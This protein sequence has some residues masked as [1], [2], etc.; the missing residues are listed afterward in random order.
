VQQELLHCSSSL[1]Q[2]TTRRWTFS[3]MEDN[4]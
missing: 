4:L 1:F 3:Q 2:V